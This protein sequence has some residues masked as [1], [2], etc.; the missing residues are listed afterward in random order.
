MA[1]EKKGVL[2]VSILAREG[3]TD[4][5]RGRLEPLQPSTQLARSSAT[6]TGL[7]EVRVFPIRPQQAA[8]PAF[9]R[10]TV[11]RDVSRLENREI[12]G[13]LGKGVDL[14]TGQPSR[15]FHY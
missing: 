12:V 9:S 15:S 14:K 6:L 2:G 11:D 3:V 1:G 8:I 10:E 13:V 4:S 7:H 5:L